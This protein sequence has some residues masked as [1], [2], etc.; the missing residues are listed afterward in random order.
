M[1]RWPN[2][3]T[4]V[5]EVTSHE[6]EGVWISRGACKCTKVTDCVTRTVYYIERTIT[7]II[8]GS[9]LANLDRVCEV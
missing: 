5:T 7:E 3:P 6:N 1:F 4:V 2:F 8:N 9:E